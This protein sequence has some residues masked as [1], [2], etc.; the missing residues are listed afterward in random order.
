MSLSHI[1][2]I[3]ACA[4]HK[5]LWWPFLKVCT[6]WQTQCYIISVQLPICK[7]GIKGD[8]KVIH[9]VKSKRSAVRAPLICDIICFQPWQTL[10][11]YPCMTGSKKIVFGWGWQTQR[12]VKVGGTSFLIFFHCEAVSHNEKLGNP[13]VQSSVNRIRLQCAFLFTNMQT[14]VLLIIMTMLEPVCTAQRT[15]SNSVVSLSLL[16][17]STSIGPAVFWLYELH[18]QE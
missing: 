14:K 10:K 4:H 6:V 7:A 16:I 13:I 3:Q 8:R 5:A 1:I 12:D 17:N 11:C 18:S 9:I 15:Q 2:K